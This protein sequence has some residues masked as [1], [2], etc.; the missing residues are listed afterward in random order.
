MESPLT[1]RSRRST[2]RGRAASSRTSASTSRRRARRAG[3]SSSSASAPGGSRSRSRA[4]GIRVIGV[5]SSPGCSTCAAQHAELAGVAEL[6][7]LR[8]G[9]LREPPV[10]ERVRAR[11][12]SLPGVPAPADRRGA[13]ARAA[14]GARAAR[15][16][17]PARLRR[18]R[19]R[20]RRHRGDPRPLDRA[21][22][23]HLGARRLGRGRAD[24]DAVGARRRRRRLDDAARVAAAGGLA[25]ACSS[26]GRLPARA[27]YGW[28]D[29]RPYAG[30]EDSIWVAVNA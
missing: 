13:A 1:T 9:D 7:D 10:E 6:L 19:A 15:P 18:L 25:R 17:R 5:D 21:R 22:A 4:E 11:D 29:R 26:G 30:G 27:C 12:L 14:R 8:L 23:G 2:T 28:F 16:R 24:A 20:P 3:R